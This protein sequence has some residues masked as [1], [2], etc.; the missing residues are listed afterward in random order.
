MLKRALL[1]LV[2]LLSNACS[3]S[4]DSESA[5]GRVNDVMGNPRLFRGDR[6]L[7]LGPGSNIELHDS[8]I[9]GLS[10]R[11]RLSLRDGTIMR[12]G[13]DSELTIQEYS[14]RAR[15]GI[16]RLTSSG[17]LYRITTGKSFRRAGSSMEIGTPVV[18]ILSG[19]ADLLVEHTVDAGSLIVVQLGSDSIK[20]KNQ[21]GE[22]ELLRQREMSTT[23][24][25][26]LPS[27]PVRIGE[28]ELDAAVEST[29][30]LIRR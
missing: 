26:F 11:L 20:V 13:R 29:S 9:T 3:W 12:I 1:I 6:Y 21:F 14:G 17:G 15:P 28:S 16:L 19:N 24:F 2:M 22:T 27:Q 25:G 23:N 5:V 18:T 8:I 7:E 30:L 10:D 4:T